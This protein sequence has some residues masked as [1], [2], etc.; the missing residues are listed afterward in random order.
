MVLPRESFCH[1]L[2]FPQEYNRLTT[3]LVH[4]NPRQLDDYPV[5]IFRQKRF[6]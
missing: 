6:S 5:Y 1:I 4:Q 3:V 2:N